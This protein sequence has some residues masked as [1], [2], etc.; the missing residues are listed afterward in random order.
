MMILW[1]E[2]LAFLAVPKTGS[3]AIESILAPM[4]AITFQRPPMVKH[5]TLQRFNRFMLPYLDK[6]GLGDVETFAVMREPVAWLGSWYRYRQRPE[7]D[8]SAKSTLGLSFDAFV[9]AYL[10][11]GKRPAF[12]DLGSQARQLSKSRGQI[13]V[14]HLFRYEDLGDL[15]E[16]LQQK[17]GRA[18][19]LP[20][21]NVSPQM[22]LQLS[23]ELD[24]HLRQAYAFDFSV[25]EGLRAAKP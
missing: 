12:A 10:Q 8:G 11:G 2:R 3:T 5:I 6:M 7:L 4:A 17:T 24:A 20:Q 18:F 22:D 1:K 13:G 15:V 21:K 9:A 23:T 25:Y 14:D 19:E 16:F